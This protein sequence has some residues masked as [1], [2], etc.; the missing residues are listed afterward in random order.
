MEVGLVDRKTGRW[1]G[2]VKAGLVEK[3]GMSILT[4]HLQMTV[5]RDEQS[6]S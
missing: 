4:G 1:V 3:T 5:I 6:I 2:L